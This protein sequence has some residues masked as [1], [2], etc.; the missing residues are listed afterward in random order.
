MATTNRIYI[1]YAAERYYTTE[2]ELLAAFEDYEGCESF[3]EWLNNRYTASEIFNMDERELAI[4][5][6]DYDGFYNFALD[7]WVESNLEVII[8]SAEV[9]VS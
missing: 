8:L 7:E 9:S 5:Q 4:L 6:E 1:H 2:T 3:E